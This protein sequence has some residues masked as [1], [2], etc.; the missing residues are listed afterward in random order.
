MQL[1]LVFY[2]TPP[3]VLELQ[4]ENESPKGGLGIPTNST[5]SWFHPLPT[6]FGE[7]NTLSF[8]LP[9]PPTKGRSIT[10]SDAHSN[11]RERCHHNLMILRGERGSEGRKL[12]RIV[13]GRAEL[14]TQLHRT[15]GQA[16][17]TNILN[18]AWQNRCEIL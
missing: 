15:L 10:A 18:P 5:W 2:W 6:D 1:G 16:L 4:K 13:S 11:S 3:Y 12:P 14:R 9:L 17:I 7:G 8:H